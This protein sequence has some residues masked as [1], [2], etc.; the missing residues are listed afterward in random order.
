MEAKVKKA[1]S[2]LGFLRRNLRVGSQSVKERA[3]FALVRPTLEYASSI[4]DP[5]DKTLINKIEM[6]Q[7]RAARYVTCRYRKRS[8][9]GSM[10]RELEWTSLKDRRQHQRLVLLFKITHGLVAV[11]AADY[12]VTPADRVGRNKNS[13]SYQIP[14]ANKNCYKNSFFPNTIRAWNILGEE[15]VTGSLEQFKAGLAKV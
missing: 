14:R 7:R 12:G 4:W 2:T 5:A 10:L 1:N 11:N 3:Y 9:V 13:L 15:L 6:V 8:S